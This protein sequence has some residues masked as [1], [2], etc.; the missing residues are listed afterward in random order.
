M[1]VR[2][3]QRLSWSRVQRESEHLTEW[4]MQFLGDASTLSRGWTP[5]KEDAQKALSLSSFA[6]SGVRNQ[7]HWPDYGYRL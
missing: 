6:V 2:R 7:Y 1:W 3:K 4:M 5:S